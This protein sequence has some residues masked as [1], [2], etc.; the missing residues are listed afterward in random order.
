LAH[1]KH[2]PGTFAAQGEKQMDVKLMQNNDARKC[3]RKLSNCARLVA[4]AHADQ[5]PID[6]DLTLCDIIT[7]S[8]RT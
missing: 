7:S 8:V 4:I 6:L 2:A 1:I 3:L 5:D